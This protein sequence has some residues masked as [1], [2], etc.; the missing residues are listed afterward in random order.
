MAF[1]GGII[2]FTIALITFAITMHISRKEGEEATKK[3]F[4]AWLIVIGLVICIPLLLFALSPLWTE[5]SV[6]KKDNRG[7][8]IIDRE[9]F[10]GKQADWQYNHYRF[11][12]KEDNTFLFYV[13]DKE[14]IIKTY[15]GYVT[16]HAPH[17]STRIAIHMNEPSHH[18]LES[19]P[20]LY[21]DIWSF[22]YVFESKHYGN[23]FFK[24]GEWKKID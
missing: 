6:S 10:K 18:I 11:E 23:M 2:A 22:Y 20:T 13:T 5:I 12:I 17:V 14:K 7:T 3:T 4:K 1:F 16:F 24:K 8:Y 9:M 15:K 21:R 19:N